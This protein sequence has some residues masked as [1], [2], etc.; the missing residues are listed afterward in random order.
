ML[1][2]QLA[3]FNT[4]SFI[5]NDLRIGLPS[6]MTEVMINGKNLTTFCGYH[7]ALKVLLRLMERPNACRA[8]AFIAMGRL[9]EAV[10]SALV[11]PTQGE[12]N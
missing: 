6:Q 1:L 11:E 7:P 3:K 4:S 8:D 12:I 5:V 2:P 10:G 9:A